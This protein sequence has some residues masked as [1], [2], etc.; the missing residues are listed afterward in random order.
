MNLATWMGVRICRSKHLGE[1]H[2]PSMPVHRGIDIGYEAM[3]PP[4]AT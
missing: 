2:M 4:S 3:S 1:C